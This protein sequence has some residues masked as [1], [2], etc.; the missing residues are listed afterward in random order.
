MMETQEDDE[1]LVKCFLKKGEESSFRLLYRRHSPYLYLFAVRLLGGNKADAEDILQET[2]I[3]AARN[4]SNFRWRSSLRTWLC[5]ILI[6]CWREFTSRDRRANSS[7]E[8]KE[9][10]QTNVHQTIE[11]ETLIQRL[12]DACREV[13]ILHDIEGY[14]HEEIS[15]LLG[16]H[17]GTSKSQ[18]FEA[19]KKLRFWW[20]GQQ[21][22]ED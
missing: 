10:A 7:A 9:L 16:I 17:P 8:E 14:T 19:R 1:F 15:S 11:L 13:F 18:T 4:L 12:P 21:K 22:R 20:N 6:N 2:W 3:R 5:G